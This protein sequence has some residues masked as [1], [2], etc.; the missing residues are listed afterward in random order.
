VK[1]RLRHVVEW[2]G[3]PLLLAALRLV[4]MYRR[5]FHETSPLLHRATEAT[6]VHPVIDHYHEPLIMPRLHLDRGRRR[7]L[8]AID[9]RTPAQLALLREFDWNDELLTIPRRSDDERVPYYDN[10][11]FPPGDAETLH[12]VLRHFRPRRVI[13]I[14]SG[15]STKFALNALRLNGGGTLTCIEPY[16]APWLEDLGVEVVRQRVED[17]GPEPF[18]SLE[19]GDALFVDSSHVVRPQG[20]VVRIYTEILPALAHGVLV[21]VHDVFTP[22]DYPWEWIERRWLWDEQYLLEAMLANGSRYEVVLAVNLLYHEHP[23]ELRRTC[24]A[25]AER[26]GRSEP[27]SLWLQVA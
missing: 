25:L 1:Q 7:D 17:V 21:H 11:S 10:P 26:A 5:S 19:R 23:A 16:E 20:D 9:F 24:P 8:A 3:F 6:G 14:G 12:N 4:R 13:E 15:Q 2:I 18:R 22:R 27:G